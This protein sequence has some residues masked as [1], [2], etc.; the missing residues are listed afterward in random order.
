MTACRSMD[1]TSRRPRPG[2]DVGLTDE[3]SNPCVTGST[4][5]VVGVGVTACFWGLVGCRDRSEAFPRSS[6]SGHLS[7]SP[8]PS[9][10]QIACPVECAFAFQRANAAFKRWTNR[11][12]AFADQQTATAQIASDCDSA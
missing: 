2:A 12:V 4:A 11:V 6:P 3:A 9:P 8:S 5:F 7:A 10:L 1:P